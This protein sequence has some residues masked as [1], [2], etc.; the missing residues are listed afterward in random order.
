VEER[1]HF[2]TECDYLTL[3]FGVRRAN[4]SD[5]RPVLVSNTGHFIALS[6]A[7]DPLIDLLEGGCSGLD[8]I[9][10]VAISDVEGPE[11][12]TGRARLTDFL[13]GL[14]TGD[15][16]NMKASLPRSRFDS[17]NRLVAIDFLWRRPLI[18][19]PSGF[20]LRLGARLRSAVP[21]S[22]IVGASVVVAAFAVFFGFHLEI[23]A[24]WPS[25]LAYPTL[26]AV[27]LGQVVFHEFWHAVAM[28]YLKIP[29]RE[30]GV[31]LMY[32]L[33]PTAYVDRTE[34]YTLKSRLGRSMVS[35]AGPLSDCV[36][37]CLTGIL[38]SVTTGKTL[39]ALQLLLI[40][41]LYLVAVN[42][43]PLVRSDGYQAL[44]AALG[45]VN[46]RSRA[47]ALVLHL[48]ARRPLPM[49]LRDLP[50]RV[51]LGYVLYVVVSLGY[52]AVLLTGVGR[53]IAA[54]VAL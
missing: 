18:K 1:L 42:L 25:G 33:V 8:L 23:P 37:I 47:F 31:G 39:G 2:W 11:R 38:G 10:A 48:V 50:H 19:D 26:L 32:F 27:L 36:F 16:L 54:A 34:T 30:I 43:N 44:E 24:I 41:Q 5:G 9:Q 13:D 29:I 51:R 53:L 49:F 15:V 52:T 45:G 14:L 3:D 28:G 6:R 4:A 17:F 40:A 21:P 35:L 7:S 46:T 20:F 22:A 12:E